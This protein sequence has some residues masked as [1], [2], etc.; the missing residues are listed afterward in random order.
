MAFDKWH[1]AQRGW[2]WFSGC[3][4]GGPISYPALPACQTSCSGRSP[5]PWWT[6]LA[7]TAVVFG[8]VS[9]QSGGWFAKPAG[10]LIPP[11]AV[12]ILCPAWHLSGESGENAMHF[13]FLAFFLFF[14]WCHH[15]TGEKPIDTPT[16]LK[17]LFLPSLIKVKAS[18]YTAELSS[19]RDRT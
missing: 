9:G 5:N 6:A 14:E 8:S 16:H 17:F 2:A 4:S 18:L 7:C 13:N 15:V 10:P 19:S 3:T 12:C 1:P 11:N